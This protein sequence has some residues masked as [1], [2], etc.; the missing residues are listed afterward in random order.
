MHC[1]DQRHLGLCLGYV[2]ALAYGSCRVSDQGTTLRASDLHNARS[3]ILNPSSK[4]RQC[5]PYELSSS[6]LTRKRSNTQRLI[7][8]RSWRWAAMLKRPGWQRQCDDEC[9]YSVRI[10]DQCDVAIPIDSHFDKVTIGQLLTFEII[11][12]AVRNERYDFRF[13]WRFSDKWAVVFFNY[14]YHQ[15]LNSRPS[16]QVFP[17]SQSAELWIVL[18]SD[19]IINWPRA[20]RTAKN[21]FESLEPCQ[22]HTLLTCRWKLGIVKIL[23]SKTMKSEETTNMKIYKPTFISKRHVFVLPRDQRPYRKCAGYAPCSWC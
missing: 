21:V 10:I 15:R 9:V 13:S 14:E 16:W 17:V 1:G 18:V 3:T 8:R 11:S 22:S 6:I 7:R 23:T 12:G 4:P 20:T 19:V 2:P 5:I